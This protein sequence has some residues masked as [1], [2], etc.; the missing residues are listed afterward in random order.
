[1]IIVILSFKHKQ[2]ETSRILRVRSQQHSNDFKKSLRLR[3]GPDYELTV[4][5]DHKREKHL[6]LDMTSSDFQFDIVIQRPY[7]KAV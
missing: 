1:M 2:G 3:P 7:D 6:D 5:W 4:M